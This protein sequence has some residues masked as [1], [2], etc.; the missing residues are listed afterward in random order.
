MVRGNTVT[1]KWFAILVPRLERRTIC[2]EAVHSKD[3]RAHWPSWGAE[4]RTRILVIGSVAALLML[5][6]CRKQTDPNKL[7]AQGKPKDPSLS[8]QPSGYHGNHY[9]GPIYLPRFS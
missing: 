1:L 9:S 7:A 5:S 4:M 8:V 2:A 3:P 6:A